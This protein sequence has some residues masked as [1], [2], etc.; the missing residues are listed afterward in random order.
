MIPLHVYR[1]VVFAFALFQ[2]LPSQTIMEAKCLNSAEE[3]SVV[4]RVRRSYRELCDGIV[5]GLDAMG[6]KLLNED[7]GEGDELYVSEVGRMLRFCLLLLF[8]TVRTNL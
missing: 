6:V 1:T 7:V 4:V 8:Y 2:L 5:G 3:L